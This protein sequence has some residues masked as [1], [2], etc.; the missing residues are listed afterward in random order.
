MELE[1]S[2]T[3]SKRQILSQINPFHISILFLEDPS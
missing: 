3:S 1:Y 2:L